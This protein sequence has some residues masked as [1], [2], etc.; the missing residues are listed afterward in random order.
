MTDPVV[1]LIE[2]PELRDPVLVVMLQG[3]IDASGAAMAAMTALESE[4][5]ARTIAR[6]D[7]DTFIDY[8]ARRPIMELR[9][10]VNSRLV[11]PEIEL[12]AGL[13][14]G[15]NDVLLLTGH[16]PDSAWTRFADAVGALAA[17][18]GVRMMVGL[19]A[20]PYA[21][22]HTR[23]PRL[24]C[25]APDEQILESLDFLKSSV[26]VPAGM[27]AVLEHAFHGRGIPALGIWAQV[28]HYVSGMSYPG[29]VSSVDRGAPRR[30]RCQHRHLVAAQRSAAPA[31][32]P[33]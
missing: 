17:D 2:Q 3:W 20:Y 11:W 31:V 25:S 29:G 15:G 16:E 19:G 23:P 24:S 10:G 21:A 26:D 18:L 33:G 13:D 28:P 22:P 30:L 27:E 6:F 1:E 8:R 32:P 12:R 4:T 14:G 9:D 5:K 7:R